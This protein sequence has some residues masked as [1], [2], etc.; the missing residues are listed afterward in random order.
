METSFD[1]TLRSLRSE[2]SPWPMLGVLVAAGL[3]AAWTAWFAFAPVRIFV[4]TD[5]ARLEAGGATVPVA[6]LTA[7]RIVF[8]RA[9]LGQ[10]VRRGDV[11]FELDAEAA[12]LELEE[13]G[14]RLPALESRLAA[15]EREACAEA[16][17]S[18]SLIGA[19]RFEASEVD[20]LIRHA[21][22]SASTARDEARRYERLQAQGLVA[23]ADALRLTNRATGEE[24]Q[25][26]ALRL[27]RDRLALELQEELGDARARQA[28]V[29][30]ER[31]AVEGE[32][33]SVRAAIERLSHAVVERQVRAPLDGHVG[34]LTS[35]R[36][37]AVVDEREELAVLIP[38][39]ELLVV[40]EFD[41]AEATGRIA[42]GQP[43]RLRLDGFPW[44]R[45][46]SLEARVVNVAAEAENGRVRVELAP[47]DPER[48]ST[49]LLHGMTGRVEVAVETASPI[50]LVLRSLGRRLQ[51][52]ATA[53]LP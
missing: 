36:A 13:A 3:I 42:P 24:S 20:A 17:R 26:L 27:R 21:E 39:G 9:T 30:G 8:V 4:A 25:T 43:A 53:G 31:A 50:D 33:A 5:R 40:A 51:G 7:G 35:K 14:A 32:L 2:R 44:A 15:L 46:G 48:F 34:V 29:K 41:V 47:V 28:R 1:R 52:G 23:D 11:L 19:G 37:G 12:R 16:E 45:F 10:A 49:R 38:G 22:A 6:A 18:D